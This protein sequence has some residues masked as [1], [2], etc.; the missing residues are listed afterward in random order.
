MEWKGKFV[1]THIDDI[2]DMW[3]GDLRCDRFDII[4]EVDEINGN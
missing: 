3:I 4:T 2:K 1:N